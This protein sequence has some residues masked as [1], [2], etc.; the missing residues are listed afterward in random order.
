MFMVAEM[1]K[2][3]PQARM[4]ISGRPDSALLQIGCFQKDIAS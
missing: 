2:E 4:P 1:R 3:K